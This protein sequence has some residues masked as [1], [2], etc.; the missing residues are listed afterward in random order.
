MPMIIDIL[1]HIL[2]DKN[3]TLPSTLT[4]SLIY[5]YWM[6]KCDRPVLKKLSANSEKIHPV[7]SFTILLI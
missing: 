4:T 3:N 7:D 6:S 5:R 2:S 1:N